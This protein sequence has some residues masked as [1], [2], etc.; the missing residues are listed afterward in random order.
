MRTRT[1]S[2]PLIFSAAL[3][4]SACQAQEETE[5]DGQTVGL[6]VDAPR[7][8]LVDAGSG[9]RSVVTYSDLDTDGEEQSVTAT[10]AEGFA[11][12]V[13]TAAD[14]VTDAPSGQLGGGSTI[15]LPL[16]G[17]TTEAGDAAVGE[18]EATRA[19]EFTVGAATIDDQALL[20]D[21]RSAEGFRFGWRGDDTGEVST[22]QL[23]A[24][25]D[26]SDDGRAMAEGAIMSLMSLP[27]VFPDEEIGEGASWTVDSRVAGDNSLL[28]TVTYTLQSRDGDVLDLGVEV[29]QRPSLGALSLDG[30]EGAEGSAETELTVESSA[31]TSTGSLTVDLGEPLPVDGDVTYTT[32][33]VYA[34]SSEQRIVQDASTSLS[35]D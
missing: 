19:P 9:Q 13:T 17:S 33:V 18:R 6:P 21:L 23:R 1:L 7:V 27:V 10:V 16:T 34:D 20:P 22:L 29:Q 24:P 4:L 2:L 30:V 8:T 28:Q 12:S 15:V 5:A 25:E 26:A 11:Q 3:V 32:R 14:V 31:T 35:F